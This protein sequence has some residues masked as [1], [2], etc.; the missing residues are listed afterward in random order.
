MVFSE[1]LYSITLEHKL[2]IDFSGP[3]LGFYVFLL[4][5][6]VIFQQKLRFLKFL[7][8]CAVENCGV[9]IRVF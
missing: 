3:I 7:S 2:L 4:L 6:K 9:E 1:V 8:H 5:L